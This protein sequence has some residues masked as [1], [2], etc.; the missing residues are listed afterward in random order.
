MERKRW[1]VVMRFVPAADREGMT[2]DAIRSSF[3]G[4]GREEATRL[5]A[6]L[7]AH[8]DDPMEEVGDRATLQYGDTDRHTVSLL[9]EDGVWKVED[10]DE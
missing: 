10:P 3:E 6:Q 1:D 8:L 2:P 5:V 9:R 4:E 7:R